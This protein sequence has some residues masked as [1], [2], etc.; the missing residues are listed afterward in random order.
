MFG[1]SLGSLSLKDLKLKGG[2]QGA[3]YR[4]WED[5]YREKWSWDKVDLGQPLRRLLPQQLLV[6]RLRQGRHGPARG[7]GGP[8][9][10]P[11]RKGVP[12]MNPMG[13]QKGASWS[14]LLYGQERVLHPLKR[15]GERGEG[16]WKRISW[17]EALTE[18]ADAMIDAIQEVGPESIIRIGDARRGRPSVPD[19][20]QRRHHARWAASPPTSSPRSTTS[21]PASTSPS[22]SSTRLPAWTTGSTRS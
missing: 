9:R 19:P 22:A 12:D 5:L 15:A 4:S 21:A 16:K 20:G 14:Q 10:A 3:A 6:P 11:S 7:A 8:L 13:C 17:D 2:Q 1:A 18:I